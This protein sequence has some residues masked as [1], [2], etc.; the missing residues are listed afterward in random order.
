MATWLGIDVLL[1]RCLFV[2]TGLCSGIGVIAYFTGWMLTRSTTTGLA[3]LDHIGRH[4]RNAPARVVANWALAFG[5]IGS[6][7]FSTVMGVGW[8]PVVILAVTVWAG[9]QRRFIPGRPRQQVATRYWAPS[10]APARKHDR[11]AIAITVITLIVAAAAALI[12]VI[13]FPDIVVL[14]LAAALAVIGLGLLVIARRARGLGLIV[15]GVALAVAL[16]GA[17]VTAPPLPRSSMNNLVRP[18]QLDDQVLHS[19][20][21]TMDI[22]DIRIAADEYWNINLQDS[23]LGLT[24]PADQNVIIEVFFTDSIIML[25]DFFNGSGQA[26]NQQIIDDALPTLHIEVRATD[27]QLWVTSA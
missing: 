22:R 17:M 24:I 16:T 18:T 6:L 7:L 5:I 21:R 23:E 11:V 8:L 4:W 15:P 9:T 1:V 12:G 19:E 13:A 27:S 14:P 26:R 2:L 3:P 10:P 20:H 25:P